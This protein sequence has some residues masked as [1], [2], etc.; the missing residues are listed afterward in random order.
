MVLLCM[1]WS[2]LREIQRSLF[3]CLFFGHAMAVDSPHS[4]V[5]K[6]S[7]CNVGDLGSTPGLGRASEEGKG[8]LLQY[9][10]LDNSM[11]STF[12][13]VA[14]SWTRLSHFHFHMPWHVRS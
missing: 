8:Y 14:K 12:N 10:G 3:V 1:A 9:S 5:G 2:V 4:S 6:E 7:A 13:G 11:D